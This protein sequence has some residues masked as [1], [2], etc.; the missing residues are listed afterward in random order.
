MAEQAEHVR[1]NTFGKMAEHWPN[2]LPF[3]S[4][5]NY[6][7]FTVIVPLLYND[8]KLYSKGTTIVEYGYLFLTKYAL[9]AVVH[10]IHFI[11]WMFGVR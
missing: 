6:M 7:P 11:T 1:P 8:I 3:Y 5:F 4:H 9:H 2:I 10:Y